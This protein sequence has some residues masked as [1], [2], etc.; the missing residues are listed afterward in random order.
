MFA[1]G[2]HYVALLM[3]LALFISV[4][5]ACTEEGDEI[6]PTAPPAAMENPTNV[7]TP[8]MAAT[9]APTVSPAMTTP[10]GAADDWQPRDLN[11]I[12]E[13]AG[14]SFPAPLYQQWIHEYQEFAP[15][16]QIN[17]QPVGSGQGIENF[18]SDITD[19]GGTDEYISDEELAEY[20]REVFHIPTVLGAVVAAYNLSD[21][22]DLKFSPDTLVDIFL[23]RITNWSDPAIAEDNPNAMLPNLPITVVHRSDSSGTT[24]I[25]TNYLSSV[26]EEWATQ[27]GS[28]KSVQWPTGVAGEKNPGVA[29]AIKQTEGAIGYVELIYALANDLSAPSIQNAAGNYVA[30]SLATVSEAAAGFL[31]DMP[32]DLRLNIVNPPEGENAY[33][34]AG[35]TWIL[36][37]AEMT[38][39]TRAQALTDFLYWVLT[40]GPSTAEKLGYAPL[41][42]SVQEKAVEKLT[43][44]TVNGTPVFEVPEE[45]EEPTMMET[46][47]AATTPTTGTATMAGET[48]SDWQ[49]RDLEVIL[50]GAGTS[51]P[52]PL[53]QRWIDEYQDF[54]PGVQINYQLVGSGQGIENFLSDV[55]DFG[56]TD[57]YI[58]DE[59]LAEYGR[60]VFHIPT[61]LGAVVTTYNLPDVDDLKFSPDT[62]VGIFLGNIT[63]WSDPAIA[64]DNPN[65]MLPNL[66]IAVVHRTDDSGTTSIFTNYLSSVSEEWAT[67][68]GAGKTVEWP[69]GTGEE[70]NPGVASAVKQTEGAIGYV[71]LIYALANDLPAPAIQNAAGSYVAPSLETTSEA[72]AGFLA[73]MPA[74]LRMN[75]VNPPEGENA[76]PIAG[77]TWMLVRAE[78]ADETRSQALTDFLY[79]T[80]TEGSATARELGY[81]PL[82]DPV[83]ERAIEKL[84]MVTVNGTSVF[85]QP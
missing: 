72:A 8:M 65:A 7:P 16:V 60:E 54:A 42:D 25:F 48:A 1:K 62:L 77:F 70:N 22:D 28:G 27:V 63:N 26:S 83:R 32:A 51:F 20:G 58:S 84:T 80:L 82:P 10:S 31:A 14:A 6:V 79:W 15:G 33:P 49:P 52:A 57:E 73:D 11:V 24:S 67:Q 50:N 55:T 46:P 17:Y 53:Y 5:A 66:P 76:Y 81:V 47:P 18:L 71:E 37:R 59:E 19:F 29:Q 75:I 36:V 35:F 38:D 34:I 45:A 61:V 78:M 13:G 64:E 41:P 69:V 21:V 4:L 2:K 12:L 39:E 23:G 9:T 3:L 85:E 44:V 74:D 56:G 43:R 30:P 40:E 68:V